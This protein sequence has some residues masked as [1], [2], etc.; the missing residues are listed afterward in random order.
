MGERVIT[1]WINGATGFIGLNFI[2]SLLNTVDCNICV[3]AREKSNLDEITKRSL[4]KNK[5]SI[6]FD[7]QGYRGL[8]KK[9]D[10]IVNISGVQSEPQMEDKEYFEINTI[11]VQELLDQCPND[12]G[13]FLFISTIKVYGNHN[14]NPIQETSEY[15]GDNRYAISKSMAEKYIQQKSSISDIPFCILQPVFVYGKGDKSGYVPKISSILSK[16]VAPMIE[17]GTNRIS[18]IHISDLV[19][20]MTSIVQQPK[21]VNGGVFI[22]SYPEEVSLK[23]LYSLICKNKKI[24]PFYF[25]LPPFLIKI[26]KA[27]SIISS[28]QIYTLSQ[29][30]IINTNKI[31]DTLKIKPTVSIEKGIEMLFKD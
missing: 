2:D 13:L 16:G 5:L 10:I 30:M 18:F 26:L 19:A 7:T 31:Y 11:K 21:S 20:I 28:N 9:G 14:D 3:L 1:V 17:N 8:F 24:T 29:N 27:I 15:L 12:I 23:K 6:V 25:N 4:I 22:T